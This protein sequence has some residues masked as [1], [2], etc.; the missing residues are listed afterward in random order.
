MTDAE[1][2]AL[3][4][5]MAAKVEVEVR[6]MGYPIPGRVARC[7]ACAALGDTP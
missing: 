4:E 1:R 3:V 7:I 5:R 6:F 2:E